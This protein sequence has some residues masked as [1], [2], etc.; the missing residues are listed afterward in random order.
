MATPSQLL[1]GLPQQWQVGLLALL[2][3][4]LLCL[5]SYLL[6]TS[7]RRGTLRLPPGPAQLPVLGNLHLLGPLPHR[8]LRD[9]ARR[10]GP[11]MLLR[12]GTVPAVVVSSPAAAREV[13]K[14]HDADCCS[15]PDTPGARLM[16][17][18]LKD[19][20]F[21][22]YDQYWREMRKLFTVELLGM[23]GVKA[24]WH[25]RE[26]QVDK[27][28]ADLTRLSVV[29]L[30]EHIFGLA[31]GIVGTVA[32]GNV[33]GTER[34]AHTFGR[35][36]HVLDEAM[37]MMAS[38]SAE[39]FFPGAAGRLADRVTGVAARRER[40]FAELDGFFEAVIDQH[41]DPARAVASPPEE[42]GG[43]DLVDV[44]VGLM[45]Q[46]RFSREHVKGIIMDTFI[47]GIDT[48]SV[49]MLWAMSEL[50]RHP[51]VLSKAQHEVRAACSNN[52]ARVEPD[53]VPKL[54]YLKMVVKETLR[55]HPPA[56]LLLP[57]ETMRHVTICGYDVPPK[58]RV[59]VNAWAIGRDPAS[60]GP[61]AEEF[62][63]DRFQGSDAVD[64]NGAHFELVPFGAGRRICPGLAMGETNVM[65]TLANLLYCFDWALPEGMT[66][67]DVSMEEAGGLTFHR[68]TPLLLVPARW[69]QQ[70][71]VSTE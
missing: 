54:P 49:T 29:A 3:V 57:R 58:T 14:T 16:S 15:R 23:R 39:D 65:F 6:L 47:G 5:S 43:G 21:A 37:D 55:L 10:H 35:F 46:Q 8:S 70:H 13:M 71:H 7:R 30:D 25:A 51:R 11:V 64:Y 2:P 42:K 19:V 56:T 52:R 24:A 69:Y 27:L 18:G 50:V 20:A 9:L 33:Y 41:T 22:P 61:N 36:Q 62:D 38:F 40:I 28:I 68:K 34:F 26:R 1:A 4:L 63:P 48:S 53:D 44:L 67:D 31:D 12:L 59:L 32:F 17:Y 66:P 45:N 60:W